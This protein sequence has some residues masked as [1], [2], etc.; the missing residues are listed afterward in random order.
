MSKRRLFLLLSI[1]AIVAMLVSACGPSAP[2]AP[3]AA[4]EA[5]APAAAEAPAAEA[6]AQ[7]A[8]PSASAANVNPAGVFPVAKE[9]IDMTAFICPNTAVSDYEDNEFTKWLEEQTNIHLIMNLPPAPE[10]QNALNL[11]LASDDLPEVIIGCG[12]RLDQMQI[13]AEQGIAL[14]LNDYIKEYGVETKK[15]FET[16]PAIEGLITLLDG[17]IYGMPHY[18][19][20]YHCSMSQKMWVYQPWLD[21]L[22][23][24]IPTTTDEFEQMLIA[25]KTQDPNGNGKAD[26]IPLSGTKLANGGWRSPIDHFLMNSFVYNDYVTPN[27]ARQLILEDGTVKAAFVEPGYQEGLKYLARLY[28]EGLI[29][30]QAFT[31]DSAQIRQLGE[32]ETPILGAVSAGWYGVFTQNG[33]PSGRWKEYTPIAPLKGPSGMQQTPRT[34]YQPTGGH[35]NFVITK[36]AKNPEAAFRML[37]LMYSF[38]A[39]TRSVFGVEGED[40]IRSPEGT[41]S[42][43]HGKALYTVLQTWEGD[44]HNR[45]WMQTAPTFRTNEYRNAQAFNPD[46]P[47]ERWLYDWT[48]DLMEPYATSD[49]AVPPLVFTVE[50]SRQF[51]ELSTTV[52]NAVDEWFANFVTGKADVEK[53][54]DAYV[55]NLNDSGLTAFLKIYQD[56][57]DAKYKK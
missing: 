31:N 19:D 32:A 51:G 45:N 7:E 13:L 24:K 57:Y 3:A 2:A 40:W 14:P 43:A 9:K 28:S 25:F 8:A 52:Y 42:I 15:M 5:A 47:L 56:A 22:G 29:D 38:D 50:Q 11:M 35:A 44:P 36:V 55:K 48:K 20:C 17:K 1:F 33:G 12:I 37:D 18:N 39:T 46:D 34:V 16:N 54:W 6:P 21:K 4:P 41:E 49:K 10:A 53:D 30:P 27:G 26:E 23:L